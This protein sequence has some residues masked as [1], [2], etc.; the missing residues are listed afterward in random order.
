MLWVQT[1]VALLVHNPSKTTIFQF[2]TYFRV[3]N[4]A[5]HKDLD[6]K[7]VNTILK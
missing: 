6:A 2:S 7:T 1:L 3:S 4:A 5:F